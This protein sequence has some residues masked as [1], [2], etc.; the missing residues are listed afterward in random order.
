M[1]DLYEFKMRGNPWASESSDETMMARKLVIDILGR[2]ATLNW[3]FMIGVNLRGGCGN[4]L[5]FLN[6]DRHAL[7]PADFAIL[8]PGRWDRLRLFNFDRP[9]VETVRQTIL[10]YADDIAAVGF[11]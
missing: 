1:E 10:R 11:L 6:D 9:T 7:T 3:K 8:A 4:C 2:L 5:Y